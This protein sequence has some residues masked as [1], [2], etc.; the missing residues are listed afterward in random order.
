MRRSLSL[1][2][3]ALLA[4]IVGSAAMTWDR[5]S[6]P[7]TVTVSANPFDIVV[8]VR[9]HHAFV[10]GTANVDMLDTTSGKLLRRTGVSAPPIALTVDEVRGHVFLANGDGT[11]SM[12]DVANG[13]LLR[14]AFVGYGITAMATDTRA[15]VVFILGMTATGGRISILDAVR[16]SV[17]YTVAV[18]APTASRLAVLWSSA[19]RV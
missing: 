10:A 4:A 3:L 5:E 16:G 6:A 8:D 15:G 12:L 2:G 11:V 17:Q 7:V 18:G 14:T 19:P 1:I 9:A 13:A